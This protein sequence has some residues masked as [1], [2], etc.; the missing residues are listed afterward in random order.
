MHLLAVSQP[1]CDIQNCL[2]KMLAA[3]ALRV[4]SAERIVVR[5]DATF[6]PPSLAQAFVWTLLLWFSF[7]LAGLPFLLAFLNPRRRAAY[8][9]IDIDAKTSAM[10]VTLKDWNNVSLWSQELAPKH[11]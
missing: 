10:K 5:Q 1:S 2:K 9:L 3:H 7:A 4:I 6:A 8:Y 11:A